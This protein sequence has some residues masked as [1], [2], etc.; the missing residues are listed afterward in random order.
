MTI[1]KKQPAIPIVLT[2][3]LVVILSL[4][5]AFAARPGKSAISTSIDRSPATITSTA[6]ARAIGEA[7]TTGRPT[8]TYTP[9]KSSPSPG[10]K[11][12]A[13]LQYSAGGYTY[14]YQDK[15]I[16]TGHRGDEI[17]LDGT[18][19]IVVDGK[20]ES[21]ESTGY[22]RSGGGYSKLWF[23]AT[24]KGKSGWVVCP[25]VVFQDE[26]EGPAECPQ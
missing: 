20:P 23:K 1:F 25:L 17:Q 6:T 19:E 21:G 2:L 15:N 8:A 24:Y 18:A 10:G 14:L 7:V 9:T 13:T 11:R 26:P 12:R 16:L 4:A 5:I 22:I 3:G